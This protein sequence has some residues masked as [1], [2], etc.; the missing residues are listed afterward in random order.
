[1]C[2]REMPTYATGCELHFYPTFFP[3][4]TK[5]RLLTPP[6]PSLSLHVRAL[7]FV[8]ANIAFHLS[9]Q[10]NVFHETNYDRYVIEGHINAYFIIL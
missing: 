2:W 8:P 1:M 6:C 3:D 10:L 9:D 7:V 4:K 5:S